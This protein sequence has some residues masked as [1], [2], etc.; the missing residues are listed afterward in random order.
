[1]DVTPQFPRSL[2]L[3]SLPKTI[4]THKLLSQRMEEALGSK[5]AGLKTA[6]VFSYDVDIDPLKRHGLL[7]FVSYQQAASAYDQLMR[8][9]P[10]PYFR[11]KPSRSKYLINPKTRV[12][13][14]GPVRKI[15]IKNEH[16]YHLLTAP[17]QVTFPQTIPD[18]YM[19]RELDAPSLVPMKLVHKSYVSGMNEKQQSALESLEENWLKARKC[20]QCERW[21]PHPHRNCLRKFKVTKQFWTDAEYYRQP[22]PITCLAC[23]HDKGLKRRTAWW[24]DLYAPGIFHTQGIGITLFDTILDRV[25]LL[26]RLLDLQ[27]NGVFN[28]EVLKPLLILNDYYEHFLDTEETKLYKTLRMINQRTRRLL[29]LLNLRILPASSIP[30]QDSDERH[31]YWSIRCLWTG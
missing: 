8:N 5:H 23:K 29:P 16:L 2:F 11:C 27:S 21:L 6:F 30:E 25:V 9:P 22:D 24:N 7:Y 12:I 31:H 17:L 3:H 10:W 18:E 13:H 1:M 28:D 14:E 26:K 19:P 4:N 20:T 15:Y